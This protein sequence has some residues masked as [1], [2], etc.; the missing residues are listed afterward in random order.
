M[1]SLLY[2]LDISLDDRI[3][4]S[5]SVV[6][7]LVFTEV[8]QSSNSCLNNHVFYSNCSFQS[9][10]L[11]QTLRGYSHITGIF[12]L[13]VTARQGPVENTAPNSFS[14]VSSRRPTEM[15][16]VLF[17]ILCDCLATTNVYRAITYQR[18]F[19][20]YLIRGLHLDTGVHATIVI[21]RDLT[22]CKRKWNKIV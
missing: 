16:F 15:I 3:K 19:Y 6:T 1:L 18:L 14:T 8:Q 7:S 2:I 17:P 21:C 13:Y 22:T 11:L 9:D 20:S 5:V 4:S 10:C 12:R